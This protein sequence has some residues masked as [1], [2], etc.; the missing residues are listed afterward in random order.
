MTE[1]VTVTQEIT[2][3]V[4]AAGLRLRF[5]K[6]ALRL[7]ENLQSALAGIV[8]EDQTLIFTLTA[9]IRL[10]AKTAIAIEGLVR[11]GPPDSEVGNTI[12]GNHIRLC[13]VTGV[14]AKMPRVVG[15]VH[16]PDSDASLILTLAEA[17]LLGRNPF[18]PEA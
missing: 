2:E 4:A 12:H 7:I 18:S 17:R 9:P 11:D 10:P 5:D 3:K 13:R 16:N 1:T 14:S 15:F 8:P 6:V